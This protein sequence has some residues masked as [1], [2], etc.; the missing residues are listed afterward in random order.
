MGQVASLPLCWLL[1]S[2]LALV[3]YGP[4]LHGPFISDDAL[5]LVGNPFTATLSPENVLVMFDPWGEAR[6]ASNYAPLHLLASALE[7]RIFGDDTLGYH[8][9]NVLI[10]ALN[11]ALLFRLLLT[12][13]LPPALAALGA[14]FF[15]VHPANVEAVAWI[16][17]LKTNGALAFTLG[18]VL[19]FRRHPGIATALFLAGLLTKASAAAALPMAAALACWRQCNN[20]S[21]RALRPWADRL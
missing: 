17:Q 16:S 8:V 3:I 19:A 1:A 2:A 14:L 5:F 11:A 21:E 15:L 10:H 9:V 7:L 6:T 12:S 4:A 13:R 18:A 20:L